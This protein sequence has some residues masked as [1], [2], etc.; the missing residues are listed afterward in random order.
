M[1][2]QNSMATKEYNFCFAIDLADYPKINDWAEWS[3]LLVQICVISIIITSVVL[4]QYATILA[5][6]WS[7]R[8]EWSA[9]YDGA[10]SLKV[11]FITSMR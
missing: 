8:C 5:M 3:S 2:V 6:H 4:F 11:K 10:K 7:Y 9:S 1:L